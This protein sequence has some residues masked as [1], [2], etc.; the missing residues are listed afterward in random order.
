MT[1][2]QQVRVELASAQAS[3]LHAQKTSE[4][5]KIELK[6]AKDKVHLYE[7]KPSLVIGDTSEGAYSGLC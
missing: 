7:R 2:L 5:L 3:L 1:D 6:D 4:D